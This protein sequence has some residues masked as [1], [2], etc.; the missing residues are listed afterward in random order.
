MKLNNDTA[1][2]IA[3]YLDIALDV[4]AKDTLIDDAV[5]RLL[6]AQQKLRSLDEELTDSNAAAD[7]AIR[8]HQHALDKIDD[9]LVDR[10]ELRMEERRSQN[11]NHKLRAE[12]DNVRADIASIIADRDAWEIVARRNIEK[13]QETLDKI[14]KVDGLLKQIEELTAERDDA[15][16]TIKGLRLRVDLKADTESDNADLEHQI[17]MV[18]EERDELRATLASA[19]Q[20]S[21]DYHEQILPPHFERHKLRVSTL[22]D[23]GDSNE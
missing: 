10:D 14:T 9:A 17:D 16:E 6:Q 15:Q 19:E 5:D 11:A 4:L 22:T 3:D 7:E 2:V 12:L 1:Q 21:N 13:V 23:S 8:L 20:K 18:T